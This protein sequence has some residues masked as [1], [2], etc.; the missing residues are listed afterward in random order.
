[1]A[2][3]V[4]NTSASLTGKTLLKAEDA[5]TITGQKTFQLGASAPFIVQAGAA[6]V[7]NLDADFLDGEEG[8]DYHDAAQLT[9]NLAV[10]RLNSGTN[11]SVT[12]F[13][14]GDGAWAEA[15]DAIS[16]EFLLS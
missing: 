10:A 5:Q 6:K 1:L 8:T 11:A 3:T 13:W 2:V 12:T 16:T 7:A 14:R 4:S 9:G 15:G